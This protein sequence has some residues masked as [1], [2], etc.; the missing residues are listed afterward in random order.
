MRYIHND[1]IICVYSSN[2][3]SF[4]DA[5]CTKNMKWIF[6]LPLNQIWYDA[7]VLYVS[8]TQ[9][10]FSGW[11]DLINMF[12]HCCTIYRGSN[13][14]K[15][16]TFF[17]KFTNHRAQTID[18]KSDHWQNF[19]S[20]IKWIKSRVDVI[21]RLVFITCWMTRRKSAILK[22]SQQ[23]EFNLKKWEMFFP[24]S[25]VRS[26]IKW[27]VNLWN[28]IVYL[29]V[30]VCFI[31]GFFCHSRKCDKSYYVRR[32][33]GCLFKIGIGKDRIQTRMREKIEKI[34]SIDEKAKENEDKSATKYQTIYIKV[35]VIINWAKGKR[36]NENHQRI[37]RER[38]SDGVWHTT[39]K[40]S[41]R[42]AMPIW[43]T[44]RLRK[45]EVEWCGKPEEGVKEKMWKKKIKRNKQKIKK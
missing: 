19:L 3:I 22:S 11:W 4:G 24:S 25:D 7:H 36:M 18:R 38:T 21:Y 32:V 2:T 15:M 45:R 40:D 12:W 30:S 27:M 1:V 17:F 10:L 42:T 31:F 43:S 6:A 44:W 5:S 16:R 39:T 9:V 23:I 28:L 41:Q 33:T 37:G 26:G 8:I 13:E 35:V 20:K 14:M 34:N 29:C